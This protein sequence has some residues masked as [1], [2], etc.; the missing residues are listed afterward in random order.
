MSATHGFISRA[1]FLTLLLKNSAESSY[2]DLRLMA[3]LLDLG[4]SG[5]AQIGFD[6]VAMRI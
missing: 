4:P 2:G 6:P 3:M 5:L 1:L